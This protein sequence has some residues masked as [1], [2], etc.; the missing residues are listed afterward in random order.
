MRAS[1]SS[2]P[3][4]RWRSKGAT[5][6]AIRVPVLNASSAPPEELLQ[7]DAAHAGQMLEQLLCVVLEFSY[8][9]G[10]SPEQAKKTFERAQRQMKRARYR[11]AVTARLRALRQIAALLETWH[12]DAAFLEEGG[13]PKPLPITGIKSFTTLA[14]RYLPDYQP[15]QLADMMITENLLSRSG[16]GLVVPHRR[17]ASFAKPNAMMLDRM[18]AL[19]HGLLNT[20][21]H[22]TSAKG[23]R[24]G[25]RCERDSLA[26]LPT[27][28][29]PAFNETV[30]VLAQSLLDKID[31]WTRRRQRPPDHHDTRR[32]VARV[33]V[34]VFAFVE[35]DHSPTGRGSRHR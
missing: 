18:P 21:A 33:G 31:A 35:R 32:R 27:E 10:L 15:Q 22:N 2:T 23:R 8:G 4:R 7:A 26:Q 25:T 3:R 14:R 20:F 29:V 11:M 34:E 13:R 12:L 24:N 1:S 16:Q 28:C 19:V 9:Q 17:T 30:K 5:T 6:R